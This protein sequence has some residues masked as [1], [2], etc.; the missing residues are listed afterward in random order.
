MWFVLSRFFSRHIL[1]EDARRRRSNND[2]RSRVARRAAKKMHVLTVDTAPMAR[3]NFDIFCPVVVYCLKL[4]VCVACGVRA[5][6]SLLQRRRKA[7]TTQLARAVDERNHEVLVFPSV[8]F[9]CLFV[10]LFVYAFFVC[11]QQRQRQQQR[12]KLA[13]AALQVCV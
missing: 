8:F 9:V 13:L 4:F 11:R 7:T 12:E 5:A 10:C 1:T 6:A 2:V 3:R